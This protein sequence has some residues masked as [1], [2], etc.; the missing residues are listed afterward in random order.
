[1]FDKVKMISVIILFVLILLIIA[2]LELNRFRLPTSVE[3]IDARLSKVETD[4]RKLEEFEAGF[5][6]SLSAVQYDV[7][8]LKQNTAENNESIETHTMELIVL[9][10]RVDALE[11]SG[12]VQIE[13]PEDSPQ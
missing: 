10:R 4:L 7:K 11:D 5:F 12:D 13:P 2:I 9:D 1:M 8:E 6:S 3:G